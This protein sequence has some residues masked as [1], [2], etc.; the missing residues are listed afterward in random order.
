MKR[1]TFIVILFLS[2][3]AISVALIPNL[4]FSFDFE[5]FFPKGDKELD[6]YRQFVKEFETDDNFLLV[7]IERKEG[8]FEQHFLENFHDFTLKTRDLKYVTESQS[9]TKFRY[10]VKTPFA[11]TTIPAIH[12]DDPS[13]YDSDKE[14]IMQDERFVSNFISADGTTL[15]VALKTEQGIHLEQATALVEDLNTLLAK[16]P[17]EKSYIM[18]RAYFQKEVVDMTKKEV[19]ISTLIAG[20]LVCFVI[21]WIFKRVWGAV[22]ALGAILLG[23]IIFL[24]IL[25]IFGRVISAIGALYP[26]LMLILGTFDVIHVMSKY[27]DERAEGL[28]SDEA[29]RKTIKDMAL[30]TFLTYSTTAIGFLTLLGNSIQPIVDFGINA[31]IGVTVAY[32]IAIVFVPACLSFFELNQIVKITKDTDL[33]KSSFHWLHFYTKRNPRIIAWTSALIFGVSLVGISQIQTNYRIEDNLP[34]GAKVTKDFQFFEEKFAGFRPVEFAIYPQQNYNGD[35]FKVIQQMDKIENHLRSYPSIRAITSMT[36]IYKSL[37]QMNEGGSKNAYKIPDNDTTF[38]ELQ[39]FISKIP[40][41]TINILK[42]HDDK[43]MRISTRISDLGADSVKMIGQ[44]IDAWINANT[45]SSIIK[46]KRTGTGMLIDKNGE[47]V[48]NNT[49]QGLFWSVAIISILMAFIFRKWQ[50]MLIFLIPNLFPLFICGAFM[51]FYGIQLEAG[52]SIVFSVIFGIAVDDTIHT[53][54]KLKAFKD[55]GYQTDAALYKTMMEVGKPM[56]HTAIILFFGFMVMLFSVNPPSQ[57]VG[58][59]MSF[60]LASALI[61]DLF[62]LPI[63]TRWLLK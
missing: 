16:Y 23:L 44:R 11:V 27:I 12:I 52:V 57:N 42:S 59:L 34:I 58:I 33:W 55:K 4:K 24:G 41:S 37:N 15:I 21:S 63:L 30:P 5:Q 32:V 46:V 2:L 56:I 62:L 60:T 38:S 40:T 28:N 13:L 10:P 25:S 18:G 29:V 36:S 9:M 54:S 31:T 49:V 45:D 6:F 22:I 47:Y 3:S 43:K 48:R 19:A 14:K 51:G 61:S 50:V 39:G 53:L 17:F 7:A 35:D 26:V 20:I 1:N 8:V